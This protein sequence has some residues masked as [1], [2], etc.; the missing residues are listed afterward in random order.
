MMRHQMHQPFRRTH[1]SQVTR[2]VDRMKPG[3]HQIRRIPNVMQHTHR[4]QQLTVRAKDRRS[5]PSTLTN[6]LHMR[7]PPRQSVR[8]LAASYLRCP[9]HQVHGHHRNDRQR[10]T[11]TTVTACRIWLYGIKSGAQAR[12][13]AARPAAP[14]RPAAQV[15]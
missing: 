6:A 15:R 4:H 10:A 14:L 12:R 11:R 8:K 13:R 2:T 5:L 1:T 7:P 9:R 3:I